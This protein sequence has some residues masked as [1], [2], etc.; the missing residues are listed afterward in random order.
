[1]PPKQ[2]LVRVAELN[3]E[4]IGF[5]DNYSD[6]EY[7]AARVNLKYFT[8]KVDGE[9]VGY[10]IYRVLP[11][12]LESVRRGITR[13]QRRKGLGTRLSKRLLTVANTEGK[14]IYTY[15]S[16]SNLAS[17]NGNLRLGYLVRNIDEH[18]VRLVY[19][20]NPD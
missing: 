11:T 9:V 12:H 19:R 5:D 16:K 10:L 20:P 14:P 13:A 6:P 7:L 18:W 1:M 2:L 3:A 8:A 4:C 15:V 17:L